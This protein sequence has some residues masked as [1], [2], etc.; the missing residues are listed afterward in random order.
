M[1]SLVSRRKLYIQANMGCLILIFSCICIN[2]N[3]KI[4][5]HRNDSVAHYPKF[6]PGVLFV[7]PI[8]FT[9]NGPGTAVAYE[10]AI[11]TK[12]NIAVNI[13]G[14]ATFNIANT[15][16]I[17]NYNTGYYNTGNP[18]A[19]YYLLPG[20]QFY[21]S[22]S[23]HRF[24]YSLGPSAVIAGGQ[25]S[26]GYYNYNGLNLA[27]LV[28]KHFMTGLLLQNYLHYNYTPH[29]CL[30]LEAAVGST[31]LNKI[32]GNTAA[33]EFLVQGAAKIGFRI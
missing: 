17:Y 33:Q 15:N 18:D 19:M 25:K 30:S 12:K 14:I 16:K 32:G 9:E 7:A 24:N 27:E 26:S 28:Q 4:A 2:A 11:N 23:G 8:Q 6:R 22:G 1:P 20:I 3:A 13:S 21:P 29:V 5:G 31:L 10:R